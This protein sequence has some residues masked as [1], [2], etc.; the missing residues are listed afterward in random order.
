MTTRVMVVESQQ[1]MMEALAHSLGSVPDFQLVGA[2][3]ETSEVVPVARRM[4]PQVIVLGSDAF[5]Q[6]SLKTVASIREQLPTCGI[7]LCASHPTKSLV[8]R[9]I[10]LGVMSVVAKD[11]GLSHL[12]D[13]IRGVACGRVTLEADLFQQGPKA[14]TRLTDRE[15]EIL[16]LT[17]TGAS[18]QEIAVE[19]HLVPGTV[20]NL[21]SAAIRKLKG[22]N[23][24]DTA[25]IAIEQGWL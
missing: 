7:A 23:R 24:F 17:S 16:Q 5:G 10:G 9:A 19:L 13:A 4:L 15:R 3:T 2:V 1:L 11:L 21:S 25:R 22:R 12:V 8:D 6:Q 20:R 14:C 18:I